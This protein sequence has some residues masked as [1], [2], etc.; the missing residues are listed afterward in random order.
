MHTELSKAQATQQDKP[1]R[2]GRR[3]RLRGAAIAVLCIAILALA[4]RLVPQKSG[5]GTHEQL[6]LPACSFLT[7]TGLPCPTCGFT[8]SI[9]AM[10]HG[11]PVAALRANAFGVML[12]VTIIILAATGVTESAT[13]RNI[14]KIFRPSAWWIIGA[15]A[16]MLIS[17]GV[18]L[19]IGY[20]EGR[21][22]LS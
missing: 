2:P 9:S 20:A 1:F 6:G 18:K 4:I 13:G 16:C 5:Y 8:T 7:T 21:L 15:V 22:P 12:F 17:W 14:L 10:A 19:A 3:L 11:E